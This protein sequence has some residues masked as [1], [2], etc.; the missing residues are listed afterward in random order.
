[1]IEKDKKDFLAGGEQKNQTEITERQN[2][3]LAEKTNIEQIRLLI[4][5]KQKELLECESRIT[6]LELEK[7]QAE[8]KISTYKQGYLITFDQTM[9]KFKDDLTK[10]QTLI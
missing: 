7:Q 8:A 1:V 2:K 5:E 6:N 3:I 10:I 9:L 4:A